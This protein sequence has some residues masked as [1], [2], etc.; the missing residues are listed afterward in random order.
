MCWALLSPTAP[1]TVSLSVLHGDLGNGLLQKKTVCGQ[2]SIFTNGT[3]E[4][5]KI[6]RTRQLAS[7]TVT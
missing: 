2:I 7:P 6:P 3:F 4:P 1:K 5:K